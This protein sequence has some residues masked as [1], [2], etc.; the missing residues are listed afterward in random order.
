LP[1]QLIL[2]EKEKAAGM[3]AVR[4]RQGEDLGQ[5]TVEALIERLKSELP[6]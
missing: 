4:T 1:Y 3:V 2:G 6:N 5:I